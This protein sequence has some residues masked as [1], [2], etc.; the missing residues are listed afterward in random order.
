VVVWA[1]WAGVG[2]GG[3]L[4]A[5][6][7]SG[8]RLVRGLGRLFVLIYYLYTIHCNVGY[9]GRQSIIGR[10]WKENVWAGLPASRGMMV[11]GIISRAFMKL[12]RPKL[13]LGSEDRV[14]WMDSLRL[15]WVSSPFA[16]CGN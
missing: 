8:V 12:V 5:R 6:L 11:S 3:G 16:G 1:V 14:G 2:L 9:S 4:W 7:S 13:E 10:Q 15:K